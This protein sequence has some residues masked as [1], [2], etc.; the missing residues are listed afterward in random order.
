MKSKDLN[1]NNITQKQKKTIL[2]DL[3]E[4]FIGA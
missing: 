4:D 1:A 3:Q 2:L